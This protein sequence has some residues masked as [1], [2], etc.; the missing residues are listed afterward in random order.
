MARTIDWENR[1]GRRLRL[2]DLHVFFAVVQ[3]RSMAKAAAH[4]RIT[5]PAV[6][7][8][9]SE[10]EAALGVRLFDRSPQ[11]VEPTKYGTVLL[12]CGS[13]AFDELRQGIRG[14]EYLSDPTVGEL[15]I[16]CPE[17]ISSSIL[18]PII[19]RFTQQ[20]PRVILDIDAGSTPAMLRKLAERSIDLVLARTGVSQLPEPFS[21]DWNSEILFE[22]ELIIA[23]GKDNPWARR[24]KIDLAD[25]LNERWILTATDDW[26]HTVV[27]DAFRARGL[28]TPTISMRT[29]SVHLRTNL[30][31]TGQFIAA[32]PRSVMSLY[33]PRFSLKILPI[34]LPVRPWPVSIVTLK[35]RTLSPVVERFI[36]CSREVAGTFGKRPWSRRS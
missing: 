20:Y 9:I 29:P 2:R 25:L 28:Q 24:S 14:I 5:Q 23:A 30:L 27:A 11:G 19:Y 10:L 31:A 18:P 32:L 3:S 26:S 34:A 12:K 35:N 16:G 7:K 6:S 33:G 4:L 8:A 1:I 22:D 13:A 21:E 17:S 15:L 36:E